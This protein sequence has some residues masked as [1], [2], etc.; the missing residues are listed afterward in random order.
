MYRRKTVDAHAA[1][2]ILKVELH[3]GGPKGVVDNLVEVDVAAVLDEG[4][5]GGELLAHPG[6]VLVAAIDAGLG[7]GL[8]LAVG[9]RVWHHDGELVA[10]VA[11]IDLRLEVEVVVAVV[12]VEGGLA[13]VF[14]EVDSVAALAV[15][16]VLEVAAALDFPAVVDVAAAR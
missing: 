3:I 13:I 11:L 2:A 15:D 8:Q 9:G 16:G 10:A 1:A 4:R 14:V 12:H 7:N 6:D 5:L